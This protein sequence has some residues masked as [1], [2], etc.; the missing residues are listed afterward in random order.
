MRSAGSIANVVEPG[1]PRDDH[2]GNLPTSSLTAKGYL[3]LASAQG[4]LHLV[5]VRLPPVL[6]AIPL[7]CQTVR[8]HQRE[9]W[10][11]M[12]VSFAGS[13]FVPPAKSNTSLEVLESFVSSFNRGWL[14]CTQ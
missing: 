8:V 7:D 4:V 6:V 12:C 3:H 13:R 5:G 9:G 11:C 2:T 14:P 1:R 10:A